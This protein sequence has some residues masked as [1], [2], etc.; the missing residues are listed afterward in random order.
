MKVERSMIPASAGI[1][2][3]IDLKPL[4]ADGRSGYRPGF[5]VAGGPEPAYMQ[6]EHKNQTTTLTSDQKHN[7]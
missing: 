3:P 2:G 1:T 6:H 4:P 5:F 7:T